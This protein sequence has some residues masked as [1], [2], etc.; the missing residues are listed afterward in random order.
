[1]DPVLSPSAT[2]LLPS[3]PTSF[4]SPLQ[5]GVPVVSAPPPIS[6]LVAEIARGREEDVLRR[7]RRAGSGGGGFETASSRRRRRAQKKY[8]NLGQNGGG[9][10]EEDPKPADPLVYKLSGKS[11]SP[12]A[13]FPAPAGLGFGGGEGGR[14]RIL[15]SPSPTR[16]QSTYRQA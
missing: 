3:S 13:S 14:E 8:Y 2:S 4:P 10:E 5:S 7:R 15:Y 1:M 16:A 6:G 12:T 9:K 11:V